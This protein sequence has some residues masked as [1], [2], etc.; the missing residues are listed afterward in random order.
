MHTKPRWS[1]SGS[2]RRKKK[3]L[4]SCDLATK[5]LRGRFQGRIMSIPGLSPALSLF[6]PCFHNKSP[7]LCTPRH[8]D[9]CIYPSAWD[10]SLWVIITHII[11]MGSC[12]K[13]AL[14]G[15]WWWYN[16]NNILRFTISWCYITMRLYRPCPTQTL[17]TRFTHDQRLSTTSLEEIFHHQ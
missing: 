10:F 11:S 2:G 17:I 5:P 1:V 12:R 3:V 4:K 9:L 7:Y 16:N 14:V 6:L 13:L 8:V 15:K